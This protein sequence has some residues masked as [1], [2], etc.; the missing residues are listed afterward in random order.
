[1]QRRQAQV[2][3]QAAETT[4]A[5]EHTTMATS[6]SGVGSITSTGLGSGLNVTDILDRLMAVEQRPLQLLQT[7]AS[8]LNTKLSNVSKLQGYF[9]TMRDKA[10]ALTAPTLW[11]GTTA[12]SADATAVKVSTGS[13]AV[14]GSY[15]VNV[16]RLAVG[17]TVTST[18]LPSSASPLSEGT[19]TIELGAWGAGDP[20]A[21]FTAKDG[22]TAVTI[23]IGAGETSLAAIRDKINSA[24]AGVTA[25]LVTDASGT[26]LS[27]RSRDSGDENAFRISVAETNPDGDAATGLSALGYDASAASSPMARTM[28]A[29]NAALTING[30]ALSSA[31]NTLT[32]VV[33]G[34]SLNLV[35]PTSGDV[36]VTVATDTPSVKTAVTEFVDAFNTLAGFIRAQTAY[37]ADS[38]VAGALQGDQSTLSLQSQLRGVLNQ[39]SS[40]SSAWSRLSDIGLA[41]K[42]DGTLETNAA[43]LD[44]ALGNLGELKKLMAGDGDTTAEM[45][46]V[47]RFKNLADAALGSSGVFESRNAGLQA[48]VTRN[49]KDQD[50]ME[51]RLEKTR[52]RLQA[53][54]SALDTKMAT[55]N[56]LSTYMTQQI[57]QM[58]NSNN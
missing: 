5:K 8:T 3:A 56:N 14:A 23:D 34:L 50:A 45:G 16:S 38:K 39:S 55:L 1:L 29:A 10:N 28:T 46:F 42:S 47:R 21:G 7:A 6:V 27:L 52:Q 19:L 53:Q 35:K 37:N 58:N 15:A 2:A 26:R 30:I 49:T 4:V 32:D 31:S 44:N 13:N 11:S 57:T 12:T 51:L 54:Y 25:S 22:S 48:S 41:L 9:A 20:A 36:E 40:A 17:Q 18:A 43:K 33:D 24:G